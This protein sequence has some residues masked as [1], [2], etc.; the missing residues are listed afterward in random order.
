MIGDRWPKHWPLQP[1]A[2]ARWSAQRPTYREA[3]PAIIEAAVHRSQRR[4]TGNWYVLGAAG[5]IRTDRPF[6][7]TIGGIEVVAWRDRDGHLR[8]GPRACPHL[9]ADL[10]TGVIDDGTLICRW[11]GLPLTGKTCEF[12]WKPFPGHDD[13][14]L[15]WV[16]LDHLGGEEPL[17]A[18][19]P[20]ARPHGD[21]LHAVTRLVGVCEP[22]DIIANRLDPWHGNWFHPYSFTRLEVLST[23][24]E[25]DDRFLL[26]VTFR[27]GRFGIPV[28]AEF[29]CPSARTI[30]MRIVD[31]E[32]AG[33]VVE[34][35]AT[36]LGPGADGHPRTAVVEAVIA[37]SDRT[38]F[39]RAR[40]AGG[41]ITPL[42]RR[43]ANRLWRDDLVYAERRYH[44]RAHAERPIIGS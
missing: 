30:V 36:P 14:V 13:G 18:P 20:S 21:T 15:A 25:E 7:T 28:I 24:T 1:V 44:L 35:H 3:E 27:V 2:P 4:R 10:A 22:R 19:V 16:R 40:R 39:R 38:G 34:T 23:P 32:G 29:T 17:T 31:G 12:G 43:A 8:V 41:L 33:S 26:S 9:G 42:M 6:G 5:D 37:R 11:H